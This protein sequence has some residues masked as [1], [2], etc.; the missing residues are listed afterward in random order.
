MSSELPR[1]VL[2]VNILGDGFTHLGRKGA[3]EPEKGVERVLE[4]TLVS[5]IRVHPSDKDLDGCYGVSDEVGGIDLVGI[6]LGN[7]KVLSGTVARH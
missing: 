4:K 3:M 6:D 2:P 5:E 7:C 1:V